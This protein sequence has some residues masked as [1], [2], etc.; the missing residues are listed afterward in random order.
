MTKLYEIY[1]CKHCG[2]VISVVTA[3][4]GKL[5]CC[6]EPMLLQMENTTDAAQEKHIPIITV[7]G[8]KATVVVG[9]VVHPMTPEHHIAWV[10]IQ[11]G[12]KVQRVQLEPNGEPKAVFTVEEGIPI[13]AREY[14]NLHG[15]WKA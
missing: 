4:G 1:V 2:N 10:E 14:C 8:T 15:L 7:A 6:G 3:A 12:N 5:V 13:T 9:S 11:Q